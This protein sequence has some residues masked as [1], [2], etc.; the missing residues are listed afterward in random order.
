LE[1]ANLP[2]HI[3]WSILEKLGNEIVQ[4]LWNVK[5]IQKT[6]ACKAQNLYVEVHIENLQNCIGWKH[7]KMD[8][9]LK[10]ILK[11]LKI[12]NVCDLFKNHMHWH[13]IKIT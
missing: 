3:H 1:F 4:K 5:K 6:R 12:I 7:R 13:I 8:K 10:E 11:N 2:S 9:F